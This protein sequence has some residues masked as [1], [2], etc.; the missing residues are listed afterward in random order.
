MGRGWCGRWSSVDSVRGWGRWSTLNTQRIR[1]G[2]NPNCHNWT[3]TRK[4]GRRCHGFSWFPLTKRYI[5][6]TRCKRP[7]IHFKSF[8]FVIAVKCL[9]CVF[10]WLSVRVCDLKKL[11]TSD[12]SSIKSFFTCNLAP[13]HSRTVKI[14]FQIRHQMNFDVFSPESEKCSSSR[15]HQVETILTSDATK[16]DTNKINYLTFIKVLRFI[17]LNI[18][19]F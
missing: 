2:T 4:T 9:N 1:H 12:F 17:I 10:Y 3:C 18:L 19:Q 5:S 7:F 8:Y 15:V 6:Q 13:V 11:M 16:T 14:C